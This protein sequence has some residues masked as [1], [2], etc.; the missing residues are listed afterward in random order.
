MSS[1]LPPPLPRP[2]R[3]GPNKVQI[4]LLLFGVVILAAVG[5]Y[6]VGRLK[7]R[8]AV[9]RLEANV[10][11][12][13]EPLTLAELAALYPPIPD[14]EN[15]AVPLL[16]LWR[17]R[18]P[19]FWQAFAEDQHTLTPRVV[20]KYDPELPYLGKKRSQLKIGEELS[21]QVRQASQFFV[22]SNAA[23]YVAI[24]SALQRPQA[25]FPIQITDGFAALLP[26]LAELRL[27]AQTLRIA[28]LSAAAATNQSDAISAI[29]DIVRLS[30]LLGNEP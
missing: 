27:E 16:E 13:G 4:G 18:D 24:R 21:L 9:K 19:V 30:D 29:A 5:W 3:R 12:R 1:V 17:K 2:A 28:A 14:S 25:R 26:H 23:R 20:C 8:A 7:D 15:V 10:R 11:R 22:Q 6:A